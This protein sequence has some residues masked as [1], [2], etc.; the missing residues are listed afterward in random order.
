[1]IKL[2]NKTIA[3]SI[4][5]LQLL[6]AQIVFEG[7][8]K[9]SSSYL[10]PTVAPLISKPHWVVLHCYLSWQHTVFVPCFSMDKLAL[11]VRC[12]LS[13]GSGVDGCILNSSYS[14]YIFIWLLWPFPFTLA[15]KL[16]WSLEHLLNIHF[17][18]KKK[19]NKNNITSFS[20]KCLPKSCLI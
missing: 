13:L 14:V 5:F 19:Y 15:V 12:Y 3:A 6:E 20:K 2:A 10:N 4:H 8:Q 18:L 9:F 17:L 11:L 7:F 16:F 1:M